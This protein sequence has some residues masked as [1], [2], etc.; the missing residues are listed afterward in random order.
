MFSA[1]ETSDVS[2]QLAVLQFGGSRGYG[3]VA[4]EFCS[5]GQGTEHFVIAGCI[6]ARHSRGLHCT[7]L[8]PTALHATIA[9]IATKSLP[10]WALSDY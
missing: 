10:K 3:Q 9:T 2:G 1:M 5:A 4:P 7:A 8:R 6:V